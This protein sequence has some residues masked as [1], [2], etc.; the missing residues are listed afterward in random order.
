MSNLLNFSKSNF[1][2]EVLQSPVPVVVAFSAVWCGPCH[3]VKPV[4]E[5]LSE[6][7]GGKFRIGTVDADEEAE[8]V[9]QYGVRSVPMIFIFRSGKVLHTTVG[10]VSKEKLLNLIG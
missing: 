3:V 10:P 8:L 6:E 4:L 5:K 1:E 7:S 9:R 2:A